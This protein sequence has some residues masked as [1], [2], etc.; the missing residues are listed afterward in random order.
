M[1]LESSRGKLVEPQ[2]DRWENIEDFG[3]EVGDRVYSDSGTYREIKHV[4]TDK[5]SPGGGHLVVERVGED[6][7]IKEQ[8]LTFQHVLDHQGNIA[9]ID[10]P[11][12]PEGLTPTS[13]K[14]SR[15]Q[16]EAFAHIELQLQNKKLRPQDK[17]DWLL[18]RARLI[19]EIANPPDPEE[20]KAEDREQHIQDVQELVHPKT[21]DRLRQVVQRR[22]F[23]GAQGQEEREKNVAAKEYDPKQLE[24]LGEKIFQQVQE[25]ERIKQNKKELGRGDV[26]LKLVT[27]PQLVE[28]KHSPRHSN[29]TIG[30]SAEISR[31]MRKVL[32]ASIEQDPARREKI[33]L[34]SDAAVD[35]G[36]IS[37]FID[38]AARSPG[39]LSQR[40]KH[41]LTLITNKAKEKQYRLAVSILNQEAGWITY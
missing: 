1:T 13:E 11:T 28:S 41:V 18:T 3:F 8:E 37:Q 21:G 12:L 26:L 23:N 22:L 15:L 33:L 2:P 38:L 39:E 34:E 40:Q 14:L 32:A 29:L 30:A 19:R 24:E 6:G 36:D 35:R 17:E 10:K 20:Q 5:D 31:Q 9:H 16:R 4:V 7:S 25:A 27:L